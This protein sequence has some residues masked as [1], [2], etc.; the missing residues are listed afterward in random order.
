[1][2]WLSVLQNNSRTTVILVVVSDL[3]I[4]PWV[5]DALILLIDPIASFLSSMWV[6]LSTVCLTYA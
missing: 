3:Q 2:F 4:N 1:M 6:G 5:K